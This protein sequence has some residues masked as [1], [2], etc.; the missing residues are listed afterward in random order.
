MK[1]AKVPKISDAEWKVMQVVWTGAPLTAGDVVRELSPQTKWNHRTIK[2]ML[3]RLVAKGAV[4][5]KVH[6]TRHLYSP[7]V[8]REVC[9]QEAS[10]AFLERVFCG[11]HASLLV[12]FVRN[13]DLTADELDELKQLLREQEKKTRD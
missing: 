13:V 7:K 1:L 12:H 5:V 4:R 6:G 11:E 8:S 3:R 2:T 9:L 10:E